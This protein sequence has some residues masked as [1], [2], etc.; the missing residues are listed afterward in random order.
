MTQDE[1]IYDWNR[2]GDALP[3]EPAELVDHTPGDY[4]AELAAVGVTRLASGLRIVTYPSFEGDVL[5]LPDAGRQDPVWLARAI[6][7]GARAGMDICLRDDGGH[8]L[9]AGVRSLV[10]FARTLLER[11]GAN[12]ALEWW[13]SNAHG[14]ALS[15]ALEAWREGI[16]RVHGCVLGQRDML[17]TELWLVNQHLYGAWQADLSGLK[18]LCEAVSERGGVPILANRPL[19][20]ADAFRTGTGVHAAA[21]IKAHAK[22]HDWLA[23]LVYSGVPAGV[24]GYRQI[25]EIGPMAGASNVQHWLREHGLEPE[26]EA[27]ARILERAKA[28]DRVL[29]EA[30]IRAALGQVV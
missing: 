28:S 8:C 26:A 25:I 15:N 13:G 24:F 7:T 5:V 20:G 19:V 29:T 30:E 2:H 18:A 12:V 23:D 27:V 21:I 6:E 22:G 17:A 1:L 11:L 4:A 14:L 3:A 16:R 10:R 9:R